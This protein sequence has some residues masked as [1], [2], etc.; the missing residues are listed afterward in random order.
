[1][2]HSA[3]SFRSEACTQGPGSTSSPPFVRLTTFIATTCETEAVYHSTHFN[4]ENRGSLFIRNICIHPCDYTVSNP[5]QMTVQGHCH[6]MYAI[7]RNRL[8]TELVS[9]LHKL[10]LFTIAYTEQR[11]LTVVVVKN[12]V[13]LVCIKIN[14]CLNVKKNTRRNIIIICVY[15]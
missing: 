7:Q 4:T 15:I 12:G 2:D 13:C 3:C 14:S 6:V 10:W 9:L 11:K 1:M 8:F 5:R